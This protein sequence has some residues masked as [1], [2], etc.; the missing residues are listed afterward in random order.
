VDDKIRSARADAT[1]S[2]QGPKKRGNLAATLDPLLEP[3]VPIGRCGRPK[4]TGNYEWTPEID[5]L[6]IESYA[7]WGAAKAKRV[8]GLKLQESRAAEA[9]PK[10]DAVRKAVEYRI[11][12]LGLSA[13]QKRKKPD[14]S[15][16]RRWTQSETTAL[17]GALGADATI[18]SIAARTGHSV[19]AVLAKIARLDYR[20]DEV[21]GFAVYTVDELAGLIRATPRQIRHWKEK[22]WLETKNRKITEEGLAR[23]LQEHADRILFETLPRGNQVYLVD[24]GYLCP[25][26][27]TFRQ[28]VRE[29]LDSIGKQRKPRRQSHR[30]NTAGTVPRRLGRYESQ[31]AP[32]VTEQSAGTM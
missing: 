14:T 26:R 8:V 27:K 21:P 18:E 5:K 12:R 32:R 9:K 10:W 23:F 3:R 22:G 1:E 2:K 15:R 28:N 29:I 16:T 19:K 31:D 11:G 30:R 24:L 6:L 25:E 7:K 13:E 4:G 20:A 17:L